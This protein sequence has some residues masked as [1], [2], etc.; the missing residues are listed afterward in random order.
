MRILVSNDDGFDAP[1][2]HSLAL[3][4]SELGDVTVVAPAT[5]QTAKGHSLTIG[6]EI[7]VQ[8]RFFEDNIPGY[9]VWG[10]PKDCVD[11]AV[12][13]LLDHCP[14]LI[15]TGI[16]EGPNLSNDCV[17]SGTIGGAI[18][19]FINGIPSIATSLD[20]GDQ[21]D[22]DKCAPFIRQIAEW[23]MKM[24]YNRDF[25]LSVNFPNTDEDFKGV[26]V[27]DSGG[28]HTFDAHYTVVREDENSQYYV[29]PGGFV[30]LNDVIEDLDHDIYAMIQGYIVMTPVHYDMVHRSALE[31]LRKDWNEHVK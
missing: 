19:G 8:Q 2:I 26:V 16:N 20:M 5:Q 4:L 3:A 14:D 11:L 1:G 6:S 25:A 18:A 9:A 13:A 31:T 29:I 27:A 24:P 28:F 30:V 21:Y 23:F 17:S 12:D 7:R 10:T 15:V 22:Y